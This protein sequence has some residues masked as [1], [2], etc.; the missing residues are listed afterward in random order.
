MAFDPLSIPA[1]SAETERVFSD[2]KLTIS[3]QRTPEPFGGTI[4]HDS[5]PPNTMSARAVAW[6]A[7]AHSDTRA[8]ASLARFVIVNQSSYHLLSAHCSAFGHINIEAI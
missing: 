4:T 1:M 3:P 7:V 2:T 6:R 5:M 8:N